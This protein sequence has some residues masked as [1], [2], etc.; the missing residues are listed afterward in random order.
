MKGSPRSLIPSAIS[1]ELVRPKL[2]P[3][4][5]RCAILATLMSVPKTAM[6]KQCH[7]QTDKYDIRI[8]RQT[9]TVKSKTITHAMQQRAH[10]HFRRC[11]L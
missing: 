7:S 3:I 5:R 11:I 10:S 4:R 2:S 1:F 6:N 9:L 8:A